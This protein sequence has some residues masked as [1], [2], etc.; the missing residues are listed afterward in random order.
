M[1]LHYDLLLET[2]RAPADVLDRLAATGAFERVDGALRGPGLT[3]SAAALSAFGRSVARDDLELDAALSVV[4]DLDG[5]EA[6]D[7]AEAL[8]L[9]LALALAAEA[10]G[11]AFLSYLG[12]YPVLARR[13]GALVLDRGWAEA[14]PALAVRVESGSDGPVGA[15][16]LFG[17]PWATG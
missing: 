12:D 13:G 5:G 8:A 11:D 4:F 17:Q 2:E 10:P 9:D 7:E 16:D 6:R 1:S 15:D 14:R 3:V